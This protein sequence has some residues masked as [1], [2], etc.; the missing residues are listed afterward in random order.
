MN[1][2]LLKKRKVPLSMQAI[3]TEAPTQA[4]KPKPHKPK[5]HNSKIQDPLMPS[6]LDGLRLA[7]PPKIIMHYYM[8]YSIIIITLFG[9]GY[10]KLCSN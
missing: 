8:F 6:M 5:S 7:F 1:N 10:L 4:L 3:Y 9:T 2:I